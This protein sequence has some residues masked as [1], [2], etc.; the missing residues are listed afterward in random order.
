[1]ISSSGIR[2]SRRGRQY[3][4]APL[5]ARPCRSMLRPSGRGIDVA[6]A[7]AMPETQISGR[8]IPAILAIYRIFVCLEVRLLNPDRDYI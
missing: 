4:F 1:L 8:S 2:F 6:I 3:R 7:A 5:S